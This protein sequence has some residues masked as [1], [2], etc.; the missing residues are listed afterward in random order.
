MKRLLARLLCWR[1]GHQRGRLVRQDD[2]HR[3]FACP[4]CKRETRYRTTAA[5]VPDRGTP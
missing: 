3:V 4:R 2:K 1:Y 5:A